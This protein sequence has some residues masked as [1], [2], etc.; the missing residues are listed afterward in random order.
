MAQIDGREQATVR[1]S[2]VVENCGCVAR[3]WT[4]PISTVSRIC[5]LGLDNPSSFI[6][7]NNCQVLFFFE[8]ADSFP[9]S[10]VVNLV[11]A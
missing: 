4:L 2:G 10:T 1:R 6:T 7:H 5:T 3:F 11:F 8:G 9:K